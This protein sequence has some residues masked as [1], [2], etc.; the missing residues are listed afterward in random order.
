MTMQT[1]ELRTLKP[2][3]TFTYNTQRYELVS[4]NLVRAII[5]NSNGLTQG[6]SPELIVEVEEEVT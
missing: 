5:R 4:M 2:G 6:A 1:T 3:D